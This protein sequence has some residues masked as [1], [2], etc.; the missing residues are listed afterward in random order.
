MSIDP[1]AVMTQG[2]SHL[3]HVLAPLGFAFRIV[4]TGN[5][6][7]GRFCEAEFAANPRKVELHYRNHVGLVRYHIGATNAS[8]GAYMKALG[9]S[10]SYPRP[11]DG[12]MKGFQ[13]LAHDLSSILRDFVDGDGHIL[14]EAAATEVEESAAR[15]RKLMVGYVGDTRA[16]AQ[17]H[18][19]FRAK[20]YA[21]VVKLLDG[22]HYPDHLTPA[23]QKMRSLARARASHGY[24][25]DVTDRATPDR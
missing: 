13:C 11:E 21:A 19:A 14:A 23:E 5:S 22:L 4:R 12:D 25:D 3:A 7:G 1:T 10:A 8:H 2:A 6:S 24:P 20:E 15:G 16:R 9:D 18:E 17:A